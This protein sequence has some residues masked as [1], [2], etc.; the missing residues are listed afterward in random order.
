MIGIRKAK[1]VLRHEHMLKHM[2]VY[3]PHGPSPIQCHNMSGSQH[4]QL[5]QCRERLG[6]LIVCMPSCDLQGKVGGRTLL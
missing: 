5:Q 3:N 1:N 6:K 4:L 2:A